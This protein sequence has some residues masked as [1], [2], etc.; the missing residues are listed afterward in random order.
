MA[1]AERSMFESR[2]ESNSPHHPLVHRT[3]EMISTSASKLCVS[4]AACNV[5]KG[6][7]ACFE[8][9][10][11]GSFGLTFGKLGLSAQGFL[12]SLADVACST[13][14]VDFGS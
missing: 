10:Y 11:C 3:G 1:V 13:G 14:V 6:I 2:G 8:W 4:L 9:S 7:K 5:K 12:Q